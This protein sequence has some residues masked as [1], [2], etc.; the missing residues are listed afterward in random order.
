LSCTLLSFFDAPLIFQLAVLVHDAQPQDDKDRAWDEDG[1]QEQECLPPRKTT[2]IAN[3][4]G[5]HFSAVM[6]AAMS[7][8][9]HDLGLGVF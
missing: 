5:G 3:L 4:H 8:E 1:D 7:W 2:F 9:C 6:Q